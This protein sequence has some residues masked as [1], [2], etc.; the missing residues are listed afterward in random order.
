MKTVL[1]G[2][3]ASVSTAQVTQILADNPEA[4]VAFTRPAFTSFDVVIDQNKTCTNVPKERRT[5]SLP[6]PESMEFHH[7]LETGF[8]DMFDYIINERLPNIFQKAH[9]AFG[10]RTVKLPSEPTRTNTDT[11]SDERR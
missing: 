2:L 7:A 10:E 5:L 3:K 11:I 9:S 8:A 4:R 1:F 6:V